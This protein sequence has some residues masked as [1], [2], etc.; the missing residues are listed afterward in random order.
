VGLDKEGEKDVVE[1]IIKLLFGGDVVRVVL[2]LIA[3]YRTQMRL[4]S[5]IVSVPGIIFINGLIM[6]CYYIIEENDDILTS[7]SSSSSVAFGTKLSR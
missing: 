1:K 6:L 7:S 4:F 5:N 2:G 3:L